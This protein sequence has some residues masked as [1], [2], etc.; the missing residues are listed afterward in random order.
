M[1]HLS[2]KIRKKSQAQ[3][4]LYM[5]I[6][7]SVFSSGIIDFFHAPQM[8]K[9][10][11]DILLALSVINSSIK[12]CRIT[13][14]NRTFLYFTILFFL[15]TAATYVINYQSIFYYL[16]GLRNNFRFYLFF[17]ACIVSFDEE[18]QTWFYNSFRKLYYVN[19][20]IC[21]IQYFVFG[22]KQDYLGGI[23]GVT[24][25]CNGYL[26]IFL[27][28]VLS[29][30]MLD[31][32]HGEIKLKDMILI[33]AIGILIGACA[34]LKFLFVEMVFIIIF[35]VLITN[36]TWRKLTIVI[37]GSIGVLV[38]ISLLISIFPEWSNIFSVTSLW[39]VG[40]S[41]TGYTG[42]GD[43]NRLN[44]I[45]ILIKNYVKEW[46]QIMFGLGLGN[47]DYASFSFLTTPFYLRYSRLHYTWLSCP[48]MFLETGIIGLIFFIGFFLLV[49]FN[50]NRLKKKDLVNLKMYQMGQILAI[51]SITIAIYNSSLRSEAGYMMYL[52]LALPF[53]RLRVRMV[54]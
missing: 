27:T 37:I 9:Y 31:Y 49:F 40:S 21:F 35:E 4:L 42:G 25:G 5:V 7:M 39:E 45:Q 13:K 16:W 36:F 24:Q 48:F 2:I 51:I 26:H 10:S 54:E 41:N 44:A 29:N 32:I 38:G 52:F 47:C 6:F 18:D 3:Y 11:I 28:I 19:A 34:E 22:I 53:C 33:Y 23:F 1:K 15:Y 8:I 46:N 14:D 50:S 43:L 20:V 12:I 17:L 30:S